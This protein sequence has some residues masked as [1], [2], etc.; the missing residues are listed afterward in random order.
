MRLV[1]CQIIA[2]YLKIGLGFFPVASMVEL[3]LRLQ[4]DR[5]DISPKQKQ[6]LKSNLNCKLNS[7]YIFVSIMGII[8]LSLC[9]K[10]EYKF[11]N[12]W[13]DDV[14]LNELDNPLKPAI[15]KFFKTYR[16]ETAILLTILSIFLIGTFTFLLLLLKAILPER[17]NGYRMVIRKLFGIFII[18]YV[19]RTIF[20]WNYGNY[21]NM[22][23]LCSIFW[24]YF[25]NILLNL[26]WDVLPIGCLLR[27]HYLNFR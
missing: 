8:S 3:A 11:K 25:F 17:L 26:V 1:T 14:F 9:I 10:I 22:G 20:A 5:N 24:R 27:L 13:Q 6:S 19:L 4:A 12:E 15:K 23:F 7:T 16:N 2:D 21:H 18:S